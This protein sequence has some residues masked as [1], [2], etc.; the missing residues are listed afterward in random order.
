[1]V[2]LDWGNASR[3]TRCFINANHVDIGCDVNARAT[4]AVIQQIRNSD[5]S[6]EYT[7]TLQM[8]STNNRN[9]AVTKGTSEMECENSGVGVGVPDGVGVPV[10]IGVGV[11]VK[12]GDGASDDDS[13]NVP[14]G[15]T[16]T[17]N[18]HE[19]QLQ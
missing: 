13:H 15:T 14:I 16:N 8:T 18:Q 17:E 5:V 10:N 9:N 7:Q 12:V 1:M 6:N 4:K 3:S 19:S 11:D 2:I